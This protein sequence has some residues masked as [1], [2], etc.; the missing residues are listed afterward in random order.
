MFNTAFYHFQI[1]YFQGFVF[2]PSLQEI[3]NCKTGLVS[4][5]QEA[6]AVN[7]KDKDEIQSSMRRIEDD[8][9]EKFKN[10]PRIED[11]KVCLLGTRVL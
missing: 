4:N 10:A 1:H 6:I 11:L 8:M 2:Y 3:A 5:L 7:V 9:L